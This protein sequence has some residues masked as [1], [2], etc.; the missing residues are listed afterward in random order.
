[1]A[2]CE[3]RW[4][5]GWAMKAISHLTKHAAAGSW[6]ERV[7]EVADGGFDLKLASTYTGL[8]Q[9]L[10]SVLFEADMSGAR[11]EANTKRWITELMKREARGIR[12]PSLPACSRGTA[13]SNSTPKG[14]AFKSLMRQT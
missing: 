13:T 14:W 6:L 11:D 4:P 5:L 3:P 7:R 2:H 8:P 12:T 9:Q 1:M 10:N